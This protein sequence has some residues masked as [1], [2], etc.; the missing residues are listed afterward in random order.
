[1]NLLNIEPGDHV[2]TVLAVREFTEGRTVVM[3]TSA[4]MI[5]KTDLMAFSRPRAGGIIAINI[6]GDDR[7]VAARITDGDMEIFLATRQGQ[8]IRFTEDD[9]RAMGRTAAGVK[10]VELG[11]DDRVVAME[12]VAGAASLLTVSE[13]GFGKRTQ[14]GEY[15]IQ[16]RGGKGVITIKTTERNGPVVGAL[17]VSDE[18]EAM[19]ISDQGRIVRLKVGDISII[20]R[21]TQGVKL[22]GLNPGER[23]VAVARLAEPEN[24]SAADEEAAP[25]PG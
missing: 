9:V 1:V 14:I 7:L 2:A 4:G 13:N 11:A 5:K 25:E 16:R 6:G 10:G 17:L 23:L 24:G 8:A 22:I 3:S 20:G 19:L 18:D 15:P 21:N 12:A